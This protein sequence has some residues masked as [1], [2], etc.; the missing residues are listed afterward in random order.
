MAK[1]YTVERVASTTASV[2][3]VHGLVADFHE[4]T[5]WSP[6]EDIDPDMTRSYSGADSGVGA[7]YAWD[8]N[9]KAGAGSMRITNAA[10]ESVDIDVAFTRPFRSNSQVRFDLTGR[11][12]ATEVVWRMRTPKTLGMRIF[13]L[14]LNLDK[15]IGRDLDK[16]LAGIKRV[17]EGG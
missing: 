10:P 7:H 12:G 17:A 2:D 4:W 11:D 6:W 3:R 8:G 15:A 16:G 13:G 1:P 5:R 9:R 14:L